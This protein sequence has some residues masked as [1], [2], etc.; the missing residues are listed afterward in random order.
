MSTFV[1]SLA[2]LIVV[3]LLAPGPACRRVAVGAAPSGWHPA[4]LV[5]AVGGWAR[6]RAPIELELSAE[7]TG[8]AVLGG[9]ALLVVAPVLAAL[10]PAGVVMVS[11][12]RRRSR[13]RRH[14][15]VIR[16][17]LP[18]VVDLIALG[19]SAGLTARDAL[20]RT[21]DWV[22]EPF[23]AAFTEVGR[24]VDGGVS[25][26]DAII[27]LTATLG[28]PVR[29]LVTVIAAAERDGASLA[30]ALERAG[31]EARRRRRVDTE[32]AARRIPVAMLF[33]LVTCVLP[34][35]ALL[36]VV[37]ILISTLSGIQLPTSGP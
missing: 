24:R 34:A 20:A 37:P 1:G 17:G 26:V 18:E 2:G 29:P 27:D 8:I 31:D 21:V 13:A 14:A 3:V 22:P 9:V 16:R 15:E 33:P 25:F 12:R 30:P 11:T 5:A 10:V 7:A 4:S 35:F 19:V 28:D 23:V 36:T 32:E 6:R